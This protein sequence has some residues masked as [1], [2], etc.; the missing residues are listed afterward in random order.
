MG[1]VWPSA[2]EGKDPR[3]LNAFTHGL[4]KKEE[5][6]VC[7]RTLKYMGPEEGST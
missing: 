1:F 4:N 6:S 5:I 3:S 7:Y 2:L